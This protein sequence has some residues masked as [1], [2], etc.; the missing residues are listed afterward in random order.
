MEYILVMTFLCQTGDK[1]TMSINGVAGDIDGI[2]VN[3]LMDTIIAKNIFLTKY[4]NI[5]GKSAATMKEVVKTSFSV[6]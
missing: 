5:V 1:I 6:V 4:G 3:S 2:R